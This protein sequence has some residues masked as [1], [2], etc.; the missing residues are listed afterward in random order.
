MGEAG[1]YTDTGL[2]KKDTLCYSIKIMGKYCIAGLPDSLINYSQ[3]QCLIPVD[4]SKPCPP[5]LFLAGADCEPVELA[6]NKLSWI[7]DR[8]APCNSEIAG[9]HLYFSPRV[10]SAFDTLLTIKDTLAEHRDSVSLAGCYQVSAFNI[11]GIESDKSNIVCTDICTRYEL[12]NLITP[13]HDG[14]N[15]YLRPLPTL[16]NVEEVDFSVYNR[17]GGRVFHFV[18]DPQIDW[19]GVNATGEALPDGIYFYKASVRSKRRLNAADDV[20]EIKGWVQI[21]SKIKTAE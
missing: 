11:Y 10:N 17:W 1:A 15:D 20:S 8:N 2:S 19:T 18:G 12:P 13:N 4:S 3:E 5:V 7:P 9:F 21:L 14:Q 16:L 6:S